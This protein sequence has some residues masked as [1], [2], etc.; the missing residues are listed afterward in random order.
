[1]TVRQRVRASRLIEKMN[2]NPVAAKELRLK[3]N[4]R[5]TGIDSKNTNKQAN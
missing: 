3:N 4:S 5:F 2:R 1:M